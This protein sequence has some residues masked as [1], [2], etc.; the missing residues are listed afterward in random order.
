MTGARDHYLFTDGDLIAALEASQDK[1]RQESVNAT[2]QYLLN[3]D[4]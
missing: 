4:N 1:L 3:V 2:E